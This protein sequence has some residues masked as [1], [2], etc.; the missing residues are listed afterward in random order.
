MPSQLPLDPI[1]PA[2][3]PSANAPTR[4]W[5]SVYYTLLEKLRHQILRQIEKLPAPSQFCWR[6]R[7]FTWWPT[8]FTQVPLFL[9]WQK[10]CA[11][12]VTHRPKEHE[13]I[14][15]DSYSPGNIHS[16]NKPPRIAI[17][18]HLFYKDMAILLAQYIAKL[19]HKIDLFISNPNGADQ[20]FLYDQFCLLPNVDRLQV[21]LTPNRG[22][23]IA[24]LVDTFGPALL[25]Y[26]FIAH[27][28]SKK[29]LGTNVIGGDWCHYLWDG[30][31]N[32]ENGRMTKIW[33]LLENHS[34][35]YPQKYQAI[36]VQNLRWGEHLPASRV[37]SAQ[38]GIAPPSD[39]LSSTD[40]VEFPVGSMFWARSEALAPLL[41]K[42]Q[43]HQ[44]DAEEGQTDQ[45]LHHTI[46]RNLTRIALT[47]G[48]PIAVLKNTAHEN[49][50]P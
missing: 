12:F 8:L 44:F 17:H 28:H 27:L 2:A 15:L 20:T 31:L 23:D 30:L 46:E 34:L 49:A 45:T 7:A 24:P 1:D 16:K 48:K 14:D 47:S 50:Y 4:W 42:F 41:G 6:N 29:S 13:L 35:V 18:A 38:L 33:A 3:Q 43:Y 9:T 36:D 40:Y 11:Y 19:P 25:E 21:R 37:L 39:H 10:A 32:P 22:R 5:H 26:D